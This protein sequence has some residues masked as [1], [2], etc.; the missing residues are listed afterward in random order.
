MSTEQSKA[1]IRRFG[2]LIN[3]GDVDGAFGVNTVDVIATQRFF[4]GRLSGTANVGQYQFTPA[5]RT[6]PGLVTDQTGQNYDTLVFGDVA[7]GFVHRPE[8]SSQGD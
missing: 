4:L 5:S 2:D 6:Y 8:G 7:P 3:A 1:V